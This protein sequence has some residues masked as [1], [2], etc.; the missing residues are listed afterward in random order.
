MRAWRNGEDAFPIC[1]MYSLRASDSGVLL[2]C[3]PPSCRALRRDDEQSL[4][5]VVAQSE[6]SSV[7]VEHQSAVRATRGDGRRRPRDE[8]GIIEIA[9]GCSVL[10]DSLRESF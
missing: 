3:V 7:N 9:E 6:H 10:L 5:E 1:E 4:A 8:S 2:K